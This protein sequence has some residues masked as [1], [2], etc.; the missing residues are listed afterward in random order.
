MSDDAVEGDAQAV[1]QAP[2]GVVVERARVVGW[3]GTVASVARGIRIWQLAHLGV[4]RRAWASLIGV[5]GGHVGRARM[6]CK[7]CE[8]GRRVACRVT[9]EVGVLQHSA[10]RGT[11]G[12]QE[13]IGKVVAWWREAGGGRIVV[14]V[15]RWLRRVP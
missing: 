13:V 2:V 10:F 3:R 4:G 7:R 11:L 8:C 6:A 5:L 9:Q 1:V 14:C 12:R 15:V